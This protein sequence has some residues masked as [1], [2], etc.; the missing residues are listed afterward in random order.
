MQTENKEPIENNE[1]KP[2]RKYKER[3]DKGMK[4]EIRVPWRH[5]PDGT[6]DNNPSSA[7][8]YRDYYREKLTGTICCPICNK[9]GLKIYLSRHQKSKKCRE[10][11]ELKE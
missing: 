4:R 7:T 3:K 8:Y 6:Y 11:Q 10:M 9:E 2:K 5:K 1:V